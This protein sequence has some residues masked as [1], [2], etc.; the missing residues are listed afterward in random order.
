MNCNNMN[1]NNRDSGHWKSK[2]RSK[3]LANKRLKRPRK[4]PSSESS[5]VETES[6]L[7]S[8]NQNISLLGAVGGGS[9]GESVQD[10][11]SEEGSG[12]SVGYARSGDSDEDTGG[13]S[14]FDFETGGEEDSEHQTE[15]V[16]VADSLDDNFHM[17]D[18]IGKEEDMKKEHDSKTDVTADDYG[19]MTEAESR[20]WKEKEMK[21]NSEDT[22]SGSEEDEGKVTKNDSED[23]KSESEEEGKDTRT[24][25]EDTKSE[26]E[27]EGKD[28]KNNSENTKSGIEEEGKDTKTNSEDTKSGIEED[29]KDTKTNSEDTKR[30][31]EEGQKL[32]EKEPGKE[33]KSKLSE[34]DETHERKF[35]ESTAFA[36]RKP[37]TPRKEF[38]PGSK[39]F[40]DQITESKHLDN[41]KP[42]VEHDRNSVESKETTTK[43]DQVEESSTVLSSSKESTTSD[44]LFV[45]RITDS[46]P[47]EGV[48]GSEM[49]TSEMA[50]AARYTT[51]NTEKTEPTR[52]SEPIF[53]ATPEVPSSPEIES[54]TENSA[55]IKP[56]DRFVPFDFSFA[57]PQR[58]ESYEEESMS[59]SESTEVSTSE[60]ERDSVESASVSETSEEPTAMNMQPTKQLQIGGNEDSA[61]ERDQIEHIGAKREL[62][63]NRFRSSK[64]VQL[65]IQESESH[66]Q[67]EMD[68][69]EDNSHVELSESDHTDL[70]NEDVVGVGDGN[71]LDYGGGTIVD[72]ATDLDG[73]GAGV[74]ATSPADF[75]DGSTTGIGHKNRKIDF[76]SAN[77]DYAFTVCQCDWGFS[78]VIIFLFEDSWS[79]RAPWGGTQGGSHPMVDP[80]FT[81][82]PLPPRGGDI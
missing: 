76:L 26:S 6:T 15:G 4:K 36:S 48:G 18:F 65:P 21:V 12:A 58:S 66:S 64:A 35:E 25:S 77:F 34:E 68:D 78:Y 31:N 57:K 2:K 8:S 23:T 16:D 24:N 30:E 56:T 47:K 52:E 70:S 79:A 27:E 67:A 42:I 33:D 44:Y 73:G 41:I 14:G 71:G 61:T 59:E 45:Q 19:E 29:G 49:F 40:G 10:V 72:G 74:Y 11:E 69:F 50:S 62:H 3:Y 51:R 63:K 32:N 17:K 37:T 38:V 28:T 9:S 82:P 60:L 55:G 80:R 22:K 7:T 54:H 39:P 75:H 5:S 13:I 46:E 53:M 81:T 20:T 43:N 1:N